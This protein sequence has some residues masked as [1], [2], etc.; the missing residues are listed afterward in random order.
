MKYSNYIG[1]IAA[2]ALIAICFVP[3]VYIVSINTTVTGLKAEHTNFGSPGLL[4]V[5]FAVVAIAFFLIQKVWSKRANVFLTSLNFGWSFRNYL[6]LTQC[7]AGECPEKR[8]GIYLVVA[9]SAVI[10]I[11]SMLPKI[12]MPEN[13]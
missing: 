7:E 5:F 1:V 10:M 4:H 11:M 13:S 6:L 3:W 2:V 12:K 8:F 9:I